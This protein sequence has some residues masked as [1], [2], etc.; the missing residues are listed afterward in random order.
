MVKSSQ[1]PKIEKKPEIKPQPQPAP[2]PKKELKDILFVFNE[3]EENSL[4]T[5][6]A[7]SIKEFLAEAQAQEQAETEMTTEELLKLINEA[8]NE[9][10]Y[11]RIISLCEKI[12]LK[13]DTSKDLQAYSNNKMA[14]A[15][16][17][18]SDAYNALKHFS[19]AQELYK[20]L[21]DTQKILENNFYIAKMNYLMFKREEA[22]KIL[23]TPT[24]TDMP[25]N[26][27]INSNLLLLTSIWKRET[28]TGPLKY[29]KKR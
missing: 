17:S 16:A 24:G 13:N 23:T 9:Y 10:N 14:M 28:K 20:E 7:D 18:L 4:L 8:E 15:Y 11:Q 6:I 25:K 12:I 21:N 22:K 26:L 1:P 27:Q 19:A 29:V 5:G 2:P 3:E